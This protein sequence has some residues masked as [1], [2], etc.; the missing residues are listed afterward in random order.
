MCNEPLTVG[1]G[2]SMAKVSWRGRRGSQRWIS[3]A[4]HCAR[5]L[6]SAWAALYSGFFIRRPQRESN[7]TVSRVSHEQIIAPGRTLHNGFQ[8]CREQEA[9]GDQRFGS[10][11]DLLQVCPLRRVTFGD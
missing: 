8:V 4:S 5:H 9:L 3:Q 10:L 11:L 1:G 6:V 7:D 2:V